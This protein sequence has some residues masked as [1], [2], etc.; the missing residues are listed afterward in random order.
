MKV[1]VIVKLVMVHRYI[2]MQY[3][4]LP[5]LFELDEL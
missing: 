3:H 5:I 4:P 1:S 2:I